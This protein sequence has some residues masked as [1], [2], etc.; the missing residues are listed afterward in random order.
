MASEDR[1]ATQA[2]GLFR[3]LAEKPWEWSFYAAVRQIEA[4]HPDRDGLGNTRQLRDD[5]IRLGQDPSLAF[6]PAEIEGLHFGENGRP[7]QIRVWFQG[8]FGPNGPLPLHLTE[9]ARSRE[10]NDHDSTL[11]RFADVFHHRFLSLFYR[12]WANAQPAVHYDVPSRDRFRT[13]LGSLQGTAT[14]GRPD[15]ALG[16]WSRL[17]Y[18]G[19]LASAAKSA[20]SL[21]SL[22]QDLF[23]VPVKVREYIG[24]WLPLPS[25]DHLRL[26]ENPGTGTLG[27]NAVLGA[28]V[29][30]RQHRFRVVMGPLTHARF[31]KLLPRRRDLHRLVAAIRQFSGD[32]HSWDVQLVLPASEVPALCLGKQGYLGQTSWLQSENRQDEATDAILRPALGLA[33]ATE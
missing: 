5:P 33:F 28:R 30:G 10:H 3:D 14:G 29:W 13:Y 11:A 16:D 21:K 15:D 25:S 26:G 9:Y 22:L 32:E 18:T 2:L 24:E 19:H 7:P 6:A 23:Q 20:T 17:F 31:R 8:L 4:L 1:T 12:A 27:H